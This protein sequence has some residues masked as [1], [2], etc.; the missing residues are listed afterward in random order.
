[1][2]HTH[3]DFQEAVGI[4]EETVKEMKKENLL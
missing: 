2:Q 3:E 4:I 1:L